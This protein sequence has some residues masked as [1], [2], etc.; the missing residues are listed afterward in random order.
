MV[1]QRNIP[2]KVKDRINRYRIGFCDVTAP[3]NER[4]LVAALIPPGVLC[5]HKV[6][7]ILYPEN[8]EWAYPL[9][10]AAANSLC[11]DFLARKKVTL[12][13]ALNVLD[14]LPFPRLRPGDPVLD[15]LAPLVLRLTCTSPDMTEFW[16]SMVQYGWTSPVP[17]SKVPEEA[18]L[19]DQARA[20]ARA[21]IDAIVAMHVFQLDRKQLE[22]ILTTFPTLERNETRK[23]GA[24]RTRDLVL[25]A[26][27]RV[28]IANLTTDVPL[29]DD[30][31]YISTPGHGPRHVGAG[32]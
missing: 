31:I 8:T 7:T 19:N 24:Y 20:E 17:Q 16:N 4:S 29:V 11:M 21:E 1:P 30:G 13:M 5:G 3:R 10:L 32:E 14:S 15:H 28:A 27:D 2:N 26:Y 25:A 23:Y 18:L 12:T 9:W 6:P 22:H